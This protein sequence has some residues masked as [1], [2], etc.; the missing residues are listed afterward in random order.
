MAS[1][2]SPLHPEDRRNA[3]PERRIRVLLVGGHKLGRDGLTF[4]L[5]SDAAIAVVADGD[6][7]TD[8]F[9]R[10]DGPPPDVVLVDIDRD[11]ASAAQSL[12]QVKR[13]ASASRV[14]VLASGTDRDLAGRLVLAGAMGIVSK[15][16]PGEHLLDA[17][18]KVHEGELWIDRATSAQIIADMAA[19]RGRVAA[20]PA[21]ARIASLT[22]R[23]RDVIRLVAEGLSNKAIA[24]RMQIS[25]NTVRHH[26]T[27]IFS[28]LEVADRLALVVYTYR[29]K[30]G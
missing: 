10:A 28:K 17:I 22:P 7:A 1:I 16:R 6:D 26:L 24:V 9:A 4:L 29:H 15:D 2:D 25:D 18:S 23:E 5:S 30:V 19:R 13:L 12:A 3:E 11:P 14:L 8:A 27:S 20:D 21:Q